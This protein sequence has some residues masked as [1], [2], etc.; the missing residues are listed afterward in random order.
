MT[1]DGDAARAEPLLE[2]EERASAAIVAATSGDAMKALEGV[3][4]RGMVSHH[5]AQAVQH[6]Q[7]AVKHAVSGDPGPVAVVFDSASLRGRVGPTS[8]PRLYRARGYLDVAAPAPDP[9]DV[10]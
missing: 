4:K 1:I 5:P 7:L 2:E 10:A 8:V 9:D 6:V 3:T